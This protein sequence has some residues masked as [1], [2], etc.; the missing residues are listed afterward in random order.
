LEKARA[1]LAKREAL[2]AGSPDARELTRRALGALVKSYGAEGPE[3]AKR[4]A[5]IE[6]G[7]ARLALTVRMGPAGKPEYD[8]AEVRRAIEELES[9]LA[10]YPDYVR[11]R[12]QAGLACQYMVQA[13]HAEFADRAV[14][15]LGKVIELD[16]DGPLGGQAASLREAL[17]LRRAAGG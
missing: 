6:A 11:G 8:P 4:A 7:L 12:Y 1:V 2:P 3:G 17:I 13:G 5:E 15:H 16:P 10:A 14:R 9:G